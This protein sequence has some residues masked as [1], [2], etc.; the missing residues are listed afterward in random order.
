MHLSQKNAFSASEQLKSCLNDIKDWMATSKFKLNPDEFIL[1][2][3]NTQR[4]R[5]KACLPIYILGIPLCPAE[6][7]KILGNTMWFDSDFSCS[8]HVQRACKIFFC[9]FFFATQGLQNGWTVSYSWYQTV[10][11]VHTSKRAGG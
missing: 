5:L 7:V 3:S 1:I 11:H 4:D 6:P 10:V 2:S 9:F 8:K